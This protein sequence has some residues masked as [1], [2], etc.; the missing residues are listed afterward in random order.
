MERI[1]AKDMALLELWGEIEANLLAG[2]EF[3]AK[4]PSLA[5]PHAVRAPSSVS[6]SFSM[7]ETLYVEVAFLSNDELLKYVGATAKGLGLQLEERPGLD[8]VTPLRGVYVSLK[9]LPPSMKMTDVMSLTKV[10]LSM[11]RDLMHSEHLLQPD[12]QMHQSQGLALRQKAFEKMI[13]R[14]PESL[15]AAALPN[16]PTITSL[17]ANFKQ[18]EEALKQKEASGALGGSADGAQAS[19]LADMLGSLGAELPTPSNKRK[20]GPGESKAKAKAKVE[21]VPAQAQRDTRESERSPDPSQSKRASSA[22]R[23]RSVSNFEAKASTE[24]AHG[25]L[26]LEEARKKLD[27]E[28]STVAVKMNKIPDCFFGLNI[29]KIFEGRRMGRS[30]RKA[31]ALAFQKQYVSRHDSATVFGVPL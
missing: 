23:P 2:E 4:N 30:I 1:E 31:T 28:L 20:K 24:F 16:L 21:P 9:D 18:R 11:K 27:P 25:A 5:L 14:R 15:Q 26:T 12:A 29:A 6:N 8:G 7:Q 19:H 13:V 17:I 3:N 10:Q 22:Q